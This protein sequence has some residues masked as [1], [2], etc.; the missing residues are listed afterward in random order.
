MLTKRKT[1]IFFTFLI[2][3]CVVIMAGSEEVK[4][5]G[6][7]A[8]TGT[9]GI[10]ELSVRI[11]KLEK[12]IEKYSETELRTK[13][14]NNALADLNR[15]L[16]EIKSELDIIKLDVDSLRSSQ[17]KIMDSH[18]GG[19]SERDT[20]DIKTEIEFLRKEIARL[21]EKT[22]LA[23]VI[24]ENAE[25]TDSDGENRFKQIIASPYVGMTAFFV[26]LMALIIAASR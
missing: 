21:Q 10:D 15:S 23:A 22:A 24:R 19:G 4:K 20:A 9:A 26:S 8:T 12:E 5:N 3:L 6:T 11:N 7:A 17:K 25:E 14:M 2:L 16:N 1:G 18:Y 13:E